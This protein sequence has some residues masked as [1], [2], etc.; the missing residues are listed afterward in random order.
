MN[1]FGKWLSKPKHEATPVVA[2]CPYH[3]DQTHTLSVYGSKPVC[4]RC[5]AY[6]INENLPTLEEVKK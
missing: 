3:G 1:I 2:I 5:I 6:F 4:M